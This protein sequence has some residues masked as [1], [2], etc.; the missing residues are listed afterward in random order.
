MII[1]YQIV[2]F[3]IFIIFSKNNKI[4]LKKII[5]SLYNNLIKNNN[6]KK[7]KMKN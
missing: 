5:L 4:K 1:L 6:I 3:I 7:S 2:N